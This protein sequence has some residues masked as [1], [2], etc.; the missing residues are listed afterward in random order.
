VAIALATLTIE[1]DG[2][3]A[4]GDG[5]LIGFGGGPDSARSVLSTIAASMLTFLALVFTL[6]VVA[7]TSHPGC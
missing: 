6:T 1:I 4:V 7:L 5:A 3:I 2:G